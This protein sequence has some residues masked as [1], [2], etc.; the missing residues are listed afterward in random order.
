M[1]KLKF[2]KITIQSMNWN[3]VCFVCAWLHNYKP[4]AHSS[5]IGI[6]SGGE[7]GKMTFFNSH[8]SFKEFL[9][10]FHYCEERASPGPMWCFNKHGK[11]V[12]WCKKKQRISAIWITKYKIKNITFLFLFR[13]LRDFLYNN[14]D[15]NDG[16]FLK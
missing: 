12:R 16:I 11:D 7:W 3:S 5:Y 6:T 4:G 1:Y 15:D 9:N 8:S 13:T 2:W 10:G 14:N